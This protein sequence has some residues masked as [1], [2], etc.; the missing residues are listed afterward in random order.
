MVNK[1][2]NRLAQNTKPKSFDEYSQSSQ[3]DESDDESDASS[4]SKSEDSRTVLPVR[5]LSTFQ[6]EAVQLAKEFLTRSK[7]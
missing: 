4:S 2:Q 7:T 1:C 6:R 3:F 5:R